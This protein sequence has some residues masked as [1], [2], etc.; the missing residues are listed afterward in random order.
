MRLAGALWGFWCLRGYLSEG[1]RWLEGALTQVAVD[2][3]SRRHVGCGREPSRRRAIWRCTRAMRRRRRA[4]LEESLALFQKLGDTWSIAYVLLN[5]GASYHLQGDLRQ[6][7]TL[8]EQSLASF[9][10]LG[11]RWGIAW[12][13]AFLMAVLVDAA[14]S[15]DAQ[16]HNERV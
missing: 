14:G 4:L 1:R 5:L 16:N 15:A 12:A 11:D 13:L 3:R 2:R 8:V 9:R 6:A 10:T 7:E